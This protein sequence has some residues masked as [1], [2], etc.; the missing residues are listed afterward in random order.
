MP[1]VSRVEDMKFLPLQTLVAK[2]KEQ[3]PFTN[4]WLT[5][6]LEE[7]DPKSR[8]QPPK[9]I[10][11]RGGRQKKKLQ[12]FLSTRR[13][14]QKKHL[15][16]FEV[17]WKGSTKIQSKKDIRGK[18]SMN[19]QEVASF[20]VVDLALNQSRQ[21]LGKYLWLNISPTCFGGQIRNLEFTC[22]KPCK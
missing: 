5:M 1:G 22:M 3:N 12:A 4:S 7:F 19:F 21:T 15:P 2:T 11:H 14:L 18:D 9:R 17:F 8:A 10:D 16:S 20:R 6:I 13:I